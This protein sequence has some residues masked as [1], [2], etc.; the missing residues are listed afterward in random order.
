MWLLPCFSGHWNVL[1]IPNRS[2]N[3]AQRSRLCRFVFLLFLFDGRDCFCFLFYTVLD[4]F[5]FQD[6]FFLFTLEFLRCWI[7]FVFIGVLF[8]VSL[9]D[10]KGWQ[11]KKEGR[12]YINRKTRAMMAMDEAKACVVE[13]IK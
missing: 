6:S 4:T 12:N 7:F 3:A 9:L 2:E 13:L 5:V 8:F 1:A 10:K 11:M